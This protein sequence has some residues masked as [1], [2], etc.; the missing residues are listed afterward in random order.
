[1]SGK[2][3]SEGKLVGE[4]S[5]YRSM[6][7]YCDNSHSLYSLSFAMCKVLK[8]TIATFAHS[9]YCVAITSCDLHISDS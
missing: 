5:T 7:K 1:M 3:T 9:L 4:G 8:F 2:V 6:Q